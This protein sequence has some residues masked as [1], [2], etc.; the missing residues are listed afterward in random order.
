EVLGE[1]NVTGLRI[2]LTNAG[3]SSDL[4]VASVFVYI[5]LHPATAFLNGKIRLD[6]AGAILTDAWMRTELKGVCAAGT[7]RAGTA[8]RAAASA[9][10]GATA[11]IAADQYLAHGL[12]RS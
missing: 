2:R 11:A 12:W 7:V 3:S 5:G 9:G 8:G 1:N 4:E 10:E 6:N